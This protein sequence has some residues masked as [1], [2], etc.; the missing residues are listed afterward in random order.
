MNDSTIF[1]WPNAC[2]LL[3][4]A[5]AVMDYTRRTGPIHDIFGR[6]SRGG[7]FG[8]LLLLVAAALAF[9]YLPVGDHWIGAIFDPKPPIV[10]EN[11]LPGRSQSHLPNG[12]KVK[13]TPSS[14]EEPKPQNDLEDFNQP[15]RGAPVSPGRS[16]RLYSRDEQVTS[17]EESEV[18][19]RVKG[20]PI[21]P[22]IFYVIPDWAGS[23]PTKA[24]SRLRGNPQ[25]HTQFKVAGK[26]LIQV[27]YGRF[28]SWEEGEAFR[29]DLGLDR[30][31][32]AFQWVE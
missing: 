21:G 30:S 1:S 6:G 19:E 2:L 31:P 14:S 9:L 26:S 4:I 25:Y 5:L 10:V 24:L 32:R 23:N 11:D 28:S 3:V 20:H 8:S 22:A 12:A 15:S 13:S 18:A 27:G 29:L 7:P 17:S 16:P